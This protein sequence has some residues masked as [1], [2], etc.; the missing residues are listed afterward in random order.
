MEDL[1]KSSATCG[2]LSAEIVEM[3]SGCP[4][5]G[6]FAALNRSATHVSDLARLDADFRMVDYTVLAGIRR[7]TEFWASEIDRAENQIPYS[8]TLQWVTACQMRSRCILHISGSHSLRNILS[9]SQRAGVSRVW[10]IVI[11]LWTEPD[12]LEGP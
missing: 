1:G 2:S 10:P 8:A 7:Y 6:R 11:Q 5:V 3:R 12:G 4:T 9:T